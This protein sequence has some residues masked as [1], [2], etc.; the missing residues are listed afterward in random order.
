MNTEQQAG[1]AAVGPRPFSEIPRLWLRLPDMNDAFFSNELPHASV[2]N[3]F[4]SILIVT[5][6]SA[7]LSAASAVVAGLTSTGV[8]GLAVFLLACYGLI[9]TPI[10][11]YFRNAVL[12]IS[13]MLFGGRGTFTSQSYLI[14]F[15]FVPVM[16]LS[17][18]VGLIARIPTFGPY[19]SGAFWLGILIWNFVL[20]VRAFR[21]VH[22]FS[23]GRSVAA[24]LAPAALLLIPICLIAALVVMGPQIGNAFS[25][26]NSQLGTPT[27]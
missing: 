23:Q 13:S 7:A 24:V 8:S 16:I 5:G 11:F 20:D 19:I 25:A 3:T 1:S 26:I 2:V 18:L 6:I 27:P 12:L 10:G 4:F 22:G 15:Y 17:W 21:V 14:S 9:A